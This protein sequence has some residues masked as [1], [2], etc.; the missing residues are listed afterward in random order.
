LT[1]FKTVV[2]LAALSLT[3]SCGV[4]GIAAPLQGSVEDTG[5]EPSKAEP[6]RPIEP[7]VAPVVP[8]KKLEGK[9]QQ[10][11][12]KP[13]SGEAADDDDSLK[14]MQPTADVPKKKVLQGGA[15]MEGSGLNGEDPDTEDQEL[16]VQWDKW[17]NRLLWSIQ[18]GMQETLNNPD[19]SML[20]WDPDKNVM[21]SRFP[22][23]T[24]AWFF[25]EVSNERHITKLRLV[26]SSGYPNYDKAVLDS[27]QSLDG[28]SILRFPPRSRRLHVTQTAG[29]KTS[30]QTNHEFQHFGDVERYSVPGQ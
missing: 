4:P 20:R 10:D 1:G 17:R 24:C 22:M 11:D 16:M 6:L 3:L 26:R 5:V 2:A 14:G 30:E 28:S 15:M 7:M 25:C 8:A 18:S 9:A 12:S 29:I 23:G 27:V 21:M 13:L 19:D